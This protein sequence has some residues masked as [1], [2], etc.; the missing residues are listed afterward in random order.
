MRLSY[1]DLPNN[2]ILKTHSII[3]T[4]WSMFTTQQPSITP[5]NTLQPRWR[6]EG[7]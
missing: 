5:M 1:I 6:G 4:T 2:F 3:P 7:L